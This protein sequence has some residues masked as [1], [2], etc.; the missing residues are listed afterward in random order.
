M[1]KYLYE[2]IIDILFGKQESPTP[3]NWNTTKSQTYTLWELLRNPRKHTEFC[4]KSKEFGVKDTITSEFVKKFH[5][6]HQDTEYSKEEVQHMFDD[7]NKDFGERLFNPFLRLK[8]MFVYD[9]P[10]VSN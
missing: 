5:D 8:G 9:A 3:R 2:K 1:A 10:Y 6:L 4:K 7:L